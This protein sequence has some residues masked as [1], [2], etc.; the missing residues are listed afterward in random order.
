MTDTTEKLL[1]F[2]VGVAF[3]VFV[4]TCIFVSMA[5]ARPA[6]A[7]PRESGMSCF[8]T[9]YGNRCTTVCEPS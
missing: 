9:C 7:G 4:L 8:T 2:G 5:G 3:A 1:A 6:H